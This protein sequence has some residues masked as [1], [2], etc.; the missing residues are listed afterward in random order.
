MLENVRGAIAEMRSDVNNVDAKIDSLI[1]TFESKRIPESMR[2]FEAWFQFFLRTQNL[3]RLVIEFGAPVL[4]GAC[5][6]LLL[7]PL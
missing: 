7:C 1:K 3:R 6:L 2:R 4:L 5:G